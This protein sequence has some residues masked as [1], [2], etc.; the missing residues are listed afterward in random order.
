MRIEDIYVDGFGLLQGKSL[1]PTPGLTLI[2]GLN[3]A[4]KTTLLAFVRAILFGFDTKRYAAMAGGRRGGR[5][6]VRMADGRVFKVERYGDRGGQGALKVFGEDGRDHGADELTRLLQGVDGQLFR[7]VFAFGLAELAAFENLKGPEISERIYGA[8]LGLGSVSAVETEG[9]FAIAS[10]AL[11]KPGGSAPVINGILRELEEVDARIRSRD[12][13]AEH[14]DTVRRLT[15]T[16][17]QRDELAETIRAAGEEM[18]RH[19]R[20]RKAWSSWI[21]LRDAIAA[22]E[23]L[24]DVPPLPG[25]LAEALTRLETRSQE[26]AEGLVRADEA[27]TRHTEVMGQIHVDAAVLAHRDALDELARDAIR[28]RERRKEL[29]GVM[30]DVDAADRE[31]AAALGR[32]G[33][34]WTEDR[35]DAFDDSLGV[36]TVITGHFRDLLDRAA[37]SVAGA[38]SAHV[39]IERGLAVLDADTAALDEQVAAIREEEAALPPVELQERRARDLEAA[40]AMRDRAAEV[41][42]RAAEAADAAEKAIPA[43]PTRLPWTD[44]AR[45]ATALREAIAQD[46]LLGSV[47]TSIPA[48]ATPIEPA[49]VAAQQSLPWPALVIGLVGLV[50]AAILFVLD[51]P[52]VAAGVLVAA[53][54][55]AAFLWRQG[56]GAAQPARAGSDAAAAVAAKEAAAKASADFDER[57]LR[58]RDRRAALAAT[59]GLPSDAD[60]AAVDQLL[61]SCA[62]AARQADQAG[63]LRA[64]ATREAE[65]AASAAK[66]VATAAR[67]AGLPDEPSSDD[68]VV[69]ME[70]LTEARDRAA[71]RQGLVAQLDAMRA[72]REGRSKE[73]AAAEVKVDEARASA[74]AARAEWAAWLDEHGLDPALDRETAAR[75]VAAVTTAKQPLRKRATSRERAAALRMA[76]GAFVA[77]AMSLAEQVGHPSAGISADDQPAL[78]R[79]LAE[80][81]KAHASAVT[82]A[83]E[84]AEAQRTLD[85]AR[86]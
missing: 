38:T 75:M 35:V 8:G 51:A 54:A 28:D 22:R 25:D 57:R 37:V 70:R 34:G 50:G 31:L 85:R 10:G 49:P 77:A 81:E 67:A 80:L 6:T 5:L 11:F 66:A 53:L 16:E 68:V 76:R 78:E 43:S 62:T 79:L 48:R 65:T 71:R 46:E 21:D 69:A 61:G 45:E 27:V 60:T 52:L 2:R 64:A 41:A 83:A 1:A 74:E 14:A 15:E 32:L 19:D 30:R 29:D 44:L 55:V 12:L 26:A 42:A 73:L 86:E 33:A 56:S 4:G 63:L 72:R 23:A 47:A 59:V 17:A 13:P 39:E 18:R 7:N 58:A 36:E 24:G 82:A 9:R 84:Q 40:M 20:H 3:E